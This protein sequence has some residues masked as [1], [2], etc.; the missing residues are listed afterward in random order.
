MCH[1]CLWESPIVVLYIIYLLTYKLIKFNSAYVKIN[2]N[3]KCNLPEIRDPTG[4]TD[5]SSRHDN[6]VSVLESAQSPRKVLK[7]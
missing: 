6:D 2:N 4:S 1:D 5:T 3:K 7:C